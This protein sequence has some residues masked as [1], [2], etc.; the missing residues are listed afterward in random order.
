MA[1]TK[2]V[3][4]FDEIIRVMSQKLESNKD[5]LR[6][7]ECQFLIEIAMPLAPPEIRRQIEKG[8]DVP[9]EEIRAKLREYEAMV[10]HDGAFHRK[11]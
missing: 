4:T 3:T 1:E 10:F 7:E 5:W 2:G 6:S 11:H 8:L 9:D